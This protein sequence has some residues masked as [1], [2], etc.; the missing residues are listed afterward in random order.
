MA[1][2]KRPRIHLGKKETITQ[3]STDS[4]EERLGARAEPG[5]P[6]QEELANKE[7]NLEN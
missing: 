5:K 3:A 1:T 2:A 4:K 6:P 7:L